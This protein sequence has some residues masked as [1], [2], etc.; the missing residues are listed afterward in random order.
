MSAWWKRRSIRAR[1]ALWHT[2]TLAIVLAAFAVAV[3]AFVRH[4]LSEELTD[5]L[6]DDFEA[7]E[8]KIETG[9]SGV[10]L[11][12]PRH[13]DARDQQEL[14]AEI[15]TLDGRL[16]WHST[17]SEIAAIVGVPASGAA[18]YRVESL[19]SRTGEHLR[20]MTETVEAGANP[21]VLRMARS[22]EPMRHELRELVIGIVFAFPLAVAL[23][24]IGGARLARQSLRPLER[25]AD[26][27]RTIT[28]ERLDDRLPVDNPNDELGRL[29]TIFNETLSRLERSFDQLRRFTADASHELRTPLTAIRS[30]GEVGLSERVDVST[31]RDVIGSMLEETDRLTRLVDTLLV[32]SRADAGQAPLQRER[33]D[34]S[35]LAQEVVSTLG[36]LAE[37]KRVSISVHAPDMVE[38]SI[39]RL[40]IF[41]ALVN[42]VDNAVK[43]SPEGEKVALNVQWS[44]Q[45]AQIDVIDHGPGIPEEHRERIFDRFYRVDKARSRRL[46]GSG[47]GL[48]IAQWVIQAHAGTLV[49]ASTGPEGSVFRITL[50]RGVQGSVPTAGRC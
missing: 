48:S 33:I 47:L 45:G 32:L 50:P 49:L 40:L 37:E 39:D 29:A 8:E 31:Y 42:L 12:G 28:A 6:H 5:Q 26:R 44:D 10:R 3:F 14:W 46:G 18:T 9:A 13:N 25:M 30:V 20:A 43:Y 38:A 17:R 35:E 11:S 19:R 36:V 7:A 34:L 23:A 2:A 22:E 21:A 41:E 27:A 1:L 24:G 15:W 16:L 4:V